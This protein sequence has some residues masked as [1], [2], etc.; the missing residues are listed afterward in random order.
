MKRGESLCPGGS[1]FLLESSHWGSES[2]SPTHVWEGDIANPIGRSDW[3]SLNP[4][5]PVSTGPLLG[6]T[7]Y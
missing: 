6:A 7:V 1:H 3:G 2:I 4:A 5:V